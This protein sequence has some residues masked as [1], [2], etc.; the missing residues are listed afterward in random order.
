MW[1]LLLIAYKVAQAAR[2]IQGHVLVPFERL[3]ERLGEDDYV[4]G[5]DE[6]RT[7]GDYE[8]LQEKVGSILARYG[9]PASAVPAVMDDLLPACLEWVDGWL[10]EEQ[11][12]PIV[13]ALR[14]L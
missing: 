4:G 11:L 6:I 8:A 9:V 10:P 2:H 5:R 1:K 14:K 12:E 7:W 13:E 3:L